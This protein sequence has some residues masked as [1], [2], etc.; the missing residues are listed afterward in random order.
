[1]RELVDHSGYLRQMRVRRHFLDLKWCT[2]VI[3]IARNDL[4]I[5]GHGCIHDEPL[6]DEGVG[7]ACTGASPP[8]HSRHHRRPCGGADLRRLSM[9]GRFECV[10]DPIAIRD[11][12]SLRARRECYRVSL[13]ESWP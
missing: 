9:L 13:K 2:T 10:T 8:D 1:V 5:V 3:D 7:P 12:L 4:G 11:P 6:R